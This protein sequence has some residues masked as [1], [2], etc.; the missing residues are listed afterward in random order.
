MSILLELPF[1][2]GSF[3]IFSHYTSSARSGAAPPV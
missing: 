2:P 1:Q 3:V